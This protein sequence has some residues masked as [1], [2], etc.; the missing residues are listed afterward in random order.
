MSKW[1]YYSLA[2]SE[3]SKASVTWSEDYSHRGWIEMLASTL[4]PY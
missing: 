2:V 4:L 3:Q 1:Q